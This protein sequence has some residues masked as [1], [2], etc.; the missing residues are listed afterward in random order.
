M[1][2]KILP[3]ATIGVLGG[4]Q[5]GRM[6][7][8][9]ARRMGY[10]VHVLAP[11]DDTPAGQVADLEI[12][13]EYEDEDAVSQFVQ[14]VDVV[15]FEFENVPLT[16]TQV[17]QRFV[18]VRPKGSVL[19]IT[20]NR[21]REKRF[22]EQHGVAVTPYTAVESR[23]DLLAAFDRLGSPA[24]LK[25]ASWGYDG[26]GQ[27]RLETQAEAIRFCL[28]NHSTEWVLEKFVEFQC[29]LS[30]IV[31][32]GLDGSTSVYGPI[33]NFH[34][35]HVL[36]VSVMPGLVGRLVAAEAR[37]IALSIC[38]ALEVVGVLC[39]E[40][41]LSRAGQLLVNELAPR[42]HNS[43]H[44]TIDACLT[45]QFEQQVRS[46]CG[47]PLGSSEQLRPA[48]MANLLGDLWADSTPAWEQ[49]LAEPD[50]KLHLYGK[51]APKAGRKMGHLTVL[52]TAPELAEHRVR[53]AREA[54]RQPVSGS[55]SCATTDSIGLTTPRSSTPEPNT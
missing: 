41:F 22:L 47:I 10:R 37:E 31:A 7:T 42:P 46:I 40:F 27:T 13:A 12:Q 9:A 21:L 20:Q 34:R 35:N 45:S 38:R 39:V 11:E 53:M 6:L 44:L 2:G 24:I 50:L 19:H 4:G 17:A 51:T 30:V 43:G 29:E 49:V 33:T 48:A 36:D 16:A 3:G 15:T 5:L 54:L 23:Q 55:P 25:T 28:E 52:S 14:S 8:L 1:N 26:H 32:R 18:P